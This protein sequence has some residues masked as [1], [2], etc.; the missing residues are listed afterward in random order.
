MTDLKPTP[1]RTP[2]G[3]ATLYSERYGQHYHS[4]HGAATQARV[5]YLQGTRSHLHAHPQV[6]EVGFGVGMNF[7]TTLANALERRVP[8]HYIAYEFDPVAPEILA[9]VHADHP[10]AEHVIWQT[11][12]AQF[13][14]S[15]VLQFPAQEQQP[16]IQLEIRC[17]DITQAILPN[18]WATAVYLDGF[19]PSANP[20]V[21]SPELCV[22]LAAAMQPQAWLATY[23]AAGVVRR[24]LS[25]A[26]LDIHKQQGLAGKREYITATKPET[27]LAHPSAHQPDT[28][29]ET[30]CLS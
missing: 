17:Q 12:L 18:N 28:T 25:A 7:L 4:K 11:V 29:G 15:C 19:S 14:Q 24:A 5:V 20:E 3:S 22:R 10:L 8:L 1:E 6:L 16:A 13:G 26:Q 2:D 9:A 21:W 27:Q 30:T 23:S